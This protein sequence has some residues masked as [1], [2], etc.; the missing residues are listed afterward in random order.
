MN[1]SKRKQLYKWA[2]S[3][4]LLTGR[5]VYVPF[6]VLAA[7]TKDGNWQ[8]C[9]GTEESWKCITRMFLKGKCGKA[10]T[11]NEI[12]RG[13]L[14]PEVGWTNYSTSFDS[15]LF[16]LLAG[17]VGKT[18]NLLIRPSGLRERPTDGREC[19]RKLNVCEIVQSSWLLSLRTRLQKCM[20]AIVE[21]IIE[22]ILFKWGKWC[23]TCR[24]K[25]LPKDNHAF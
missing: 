21:S 8:D 14:L 22:F 7:D 20:V 24:T 25:L 18:W 2:D 15:K 11:D 17:V 4:P 19:M 12:S 16:S 6:P 13:W 10:Y 23:S 1:D 3:S 5:E 9:P